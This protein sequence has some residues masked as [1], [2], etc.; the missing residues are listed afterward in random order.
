MLPP[1]STIPSSATAGAS[2]TSIIPAVR[3]SRWS[4]R[5]MTARAKPCRETLRQRSGRILNGSWPNAACHAR[6][7]RRSASAALSDTTIGERQRCAEEVHLGDCFERT[8]DVE[9][10]VQKKREQR[11]TAAPANP[12]E[13]K[14]DN[15]YLYNAGPVVLD[16]QRRP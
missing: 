9:Q 12:T 7:W 16:V 4:P 3:A 14:S 13:K 15:E 5:P 2:G 1:R 11:R 6:M 8:L 10:C